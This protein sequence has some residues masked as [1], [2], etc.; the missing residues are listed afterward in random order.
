MASAD[1]DGHSGI[2]TR[3]IHETYIEM[4]QALQTYRTAK[5]AQQQ[6]GMVDAHGQLQSSVLTFY[7]LLRPHL[8]HED[9]VTDYWTGKLPN[10][11]DNE[12]PD[13]E[14]GKGILQVQQAT[15]TVELNGIEPDEEWTLKDWADALPQVS[16]AVRLAGVRGLG[17]EAFITVYRYQKG[18]RHLDE[19][20]TKYVRNIERRGGFMSDKTTETVER[21]RIPIDKLTRAARELSDVADELGALSDFDASQHRTKIEEEH[22][23]EIEEWQNENL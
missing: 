23:S 12:P 18:L 5:D 16:D 2:P 6:R 10:Y 11:K 9:G 21:Q 3:A 1:S 4:Q 20:E 22:I 17:D 8:K 14:R 15:R 19:W 13:P 7:E